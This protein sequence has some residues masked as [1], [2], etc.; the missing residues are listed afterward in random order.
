MD[1]S[2]AKGVVVGRKFIDITGLRVGKIVA[3]RK[4]S[5]SG[6]ALW[7]CQ[8][9]CGGVINKYKNDLERTTYCHCG[10]ESGT[11]KSKRLD[12]TGKRYGS[13]VGVSPIDKL[14][15]SQI[16]WLWK[17]DCGEEFES[18][19][20]NFVHKGS[21]GCPECVRKS[22]SIATGIRATTHGLSNTKE[23]KAWCKAKDRCFNCN[24]PDYAAYG[25]KGTTMFHG[26]VND[27]QVFYEHIG[28]IPN[29][30]NKYSLDRIDHTGNYA[31]GNVRWATDTQQARNKG[32]MS[33]NTSGVNGVHVEDKMH[34]NGISS[35]T[36]AVAQWHDLSGN[37][38]KKSFS[39]KKY[40]EELAFLA[41]CE[42]RDQAI[43]LLNLQG[44]Q[45]S[46]NHGK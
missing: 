43:R 7:E 30:G 20:G 6:P 9:D 44:A 42:A 36:Y 10:C 35:T 33:N 32:K 27:F 41:A 12:H 31:P 25:A 13:V 46:E 18:V 4:I 8:C 2:N 22:A 21:S 23:H 17:C 45:Y 38:G 5:T 19:A 14:K 34:P 16:V 26:W 37:I 28:P 3:I 24:S 15:Y 1:F 11:M 29:D 39:Y 40:G